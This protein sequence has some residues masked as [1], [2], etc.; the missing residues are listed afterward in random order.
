M[1]EAG[2]KRV[3]SRR[4]FS[5]RLRL[6]FTV[7]TEAGMGS[8]RLEYHIVTMVWVWGRSQSVLDTVDQCG[9]GKE[10]VT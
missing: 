2:P 8:Y 7:F 4:F 3:S 5:G 1:K 10:W 9:G 6:G